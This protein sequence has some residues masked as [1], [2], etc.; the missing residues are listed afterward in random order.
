MADTTRFHALI[1]TGGRLRLNDP[2][3]AVLDAAIT[4]WAKRT[5]DPASPR[6]DDLLRDK[7]FLPAI[8]QAP[9]KVSK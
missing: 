7:Q 9:I 8:E 2:D 3:W 5:T 4:A 1:Q 6:V